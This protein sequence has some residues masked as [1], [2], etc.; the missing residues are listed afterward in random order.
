MMMMTCWRQLG[1]YGECN[2]VYWIHK[3]LEIIILGDVDILGDD[4]SVIP[5]FYSVR[6]QLMISS[7]HPMVLPFAQLYSEALYLSA[8]SYH[9]S[10]VRQHLHPWFP[11]NQPLPVD[12]EAALLSILISKTLRR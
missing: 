4:H 8:G 7:H 6:L 10:Y 12:R 9:L 5:R 11:S 3:R 1:L 2:T